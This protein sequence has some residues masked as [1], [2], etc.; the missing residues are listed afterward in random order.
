MGRR[1]SRACFERGMIAEAA[2]WDQET[3][4]LMPPLTIGD[5]DHDAGL[6]IL[7]EAVGACL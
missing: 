5:D 6:D 2:G 1:L 3:L 4:K 7:E